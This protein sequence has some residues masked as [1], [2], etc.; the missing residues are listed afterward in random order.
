MAG[1]RLVPGYEGGHAGGVA[2]GEDGA[3]RDEGPDHTGHPGSEPRQ[4]IL[5]ARIGLLNTICCLQL[6]KV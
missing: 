2:G 4:R 1:P 5:N 3:R 6:Q